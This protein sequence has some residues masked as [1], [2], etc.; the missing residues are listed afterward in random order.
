MIFERLELAFFLVAEDPKDQFG[1]VNLLSNYAV[2]RYVTSF[3]AIN[4][5]T[6]SEAQNRMADFHPSTYSY[7]YLFIPQFL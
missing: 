2:S 3:I 1:L 5:T 6:H 4:R 7:Q